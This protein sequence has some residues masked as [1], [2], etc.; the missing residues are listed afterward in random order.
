MLNNCLFSEYI[1]YSTPSAL[2]TAGDHNLFHNFF[3][4]GLI[5]VHNIINHISIADCLEM[6]S[7]TVNFRFFNEPKLHRRQGAFRLSDKIDMLD[8]TFIESNCPVRIS[9]QPGLRY[10]SY[11]AVSHRR[12]H[13][14]WYQDQPQNRAR[15]R[16]HRQYGHI[17]AFALSW[18]CYQAFP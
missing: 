15:L 18:H 11:Q 7:C 6:L 10:R 12:Q 5:A 1:A 17:N 16:N 3:K 8:C 14:Y 2:N 9:V 4:Q 13:P